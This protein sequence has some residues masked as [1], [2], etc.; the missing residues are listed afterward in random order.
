MHGLFGSPVASLPA[1]AQHWLSCYR[2]TYSPVQ[3][4]D[5]QA[6]LEDADKLTAVLK[7]ES[8]LEAVRELAAQHA[9]ELQGELQQVRREKK[10]MEAKLAG[11]DLN[12]ME[13]CCYSS[14]ALCLACLLHVKTVLY[15][16]LF[17]TGDP[18]TAG[19]CIA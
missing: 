18:E 11:L 15:C 7:V 14:S 1:L 3:E 8:Q 19:T 5:L 4:Q 12:Q 16:I 6:K 10:E 2:R 17:T 13:V 9:S